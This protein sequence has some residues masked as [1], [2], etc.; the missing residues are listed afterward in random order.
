MIS[1]RARDT[2]ERIGAKCERAANILAYYEGDPV[3]NVTEMLTDLRHFC[4]ANHIRFEGLVARS[5]IDYED[6]R[7]F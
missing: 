4:E 2:L 1:E 6:E 7:D 5:E 3:E